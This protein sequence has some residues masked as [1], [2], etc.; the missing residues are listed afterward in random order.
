MI[1]LVAVAQG[2]QQ[3]VTDRIRGVGTDL[4]F[5]ESSAAATTSQT[6]GFAGLAQ[7]TLVEGDA[8]AIAADAIPGVVAVAAR[9]AIDTQL[10]AG[11]N[12]V[13]ATAGD[14]VKQFVTEAL[15]LS[16]FGGVAGIA[17]G[18]GVSLAVDG[19]EFG[20]QELTMLIQPWSIAAAFLV[21]AGVGLAS[22]SYPAYRATTVDP[23]A[24][25]RNE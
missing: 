18:S 13:G 11:A 10:V 22:G 3:G 2:T 8:T 16:L 24:A 15:T 1:A 6:D 9:V 23:I 5:I 25:L 20:A 21:A 14:I 12:N 17:I 19:R 7:S 4:I